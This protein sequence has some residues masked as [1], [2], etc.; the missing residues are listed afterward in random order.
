[1][2]VQLVRD[3]VVNLEAAADLIK[4]G[5]QL[6]RPLA[7]EYKA[8]AEDQRAIEAERDRLREKLQAQLK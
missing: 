3:G 7:D 2:Q 8:A 4:G 6:P 1:M 5:I